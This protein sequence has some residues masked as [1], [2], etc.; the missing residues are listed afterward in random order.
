MLRIQLLGI[1]SVEVDGRAIKRWPRR[2]AIA[3]IQLLALAPGLRCS[4][5]V[6]EERLS[7]EA[8]AAHS[9]RSVSDALYALRQA[10]DAQTEEGASLRYLGADAKNIWLVEGVAVID[11]VDFEMAASELFV[12]THP[13]IERIR[14]TF[15]KYDG[16]LL[17][18]HS[19]I[20]SELLMPVRIEL[21]QKFLHVARAL[22]DHQIHKRDTAGAIAT[23][24]RIVRYAPTDEDAHRR[25]IELFTSLGQ[26]HEAEQQ[27]SLCRSLL[28]RELG[29][30]PMDV[31]INSIRAARAK[32]KEQV[33]EAPVEGFAPRYQPPKPLVK[34]IGREHTVADIVSMLY[35]DDAPRLL[36]LCGIGG[37]GKTQLALEIAHFVYQGKKN[38]AV[39][40]DLTRIADASAVPR[41]IAMALGLKRTEKC[42]WQVCLQQHLQPLDLLLVLDNFEHVHRAAP[43]LAELIEQSPK[44]TVLC[45]S[46]LALL[47]RGEQVVDIEPLSTHRA[48]IHAEC[49]VGSSRS[50]AASLFLR[51]ARIRGENVADRTAEL[52]AIE[53]ICWRLDGLPLAL[54]LAAARS[55]LVGIQALRDEIAMRHVVLVNPMQDA[56]RRHKSMSELLESICA[57]LDENCK[58]GLSFAS[59][60]ESSF[61]LGL[62]VDGQL[63]DATESERILSRLLEIRVLSVD[64]AFQGASEMQYTR[65]FRLL[66]TV[67]TYA[68]HSSG[69]DEA[70]QLIVTNAF[71]DVWRRF[72][73]HVAESRFTSQELNAHDEFEREFENVVGAIRVAGRVCI[74][75]AREIVTAV[76]QPTVRRGHIFDLIAWIEEERLL[77][78]SVCQR[79]DEVDLMS[80][81]CE[82]YRGAAN[83]PQAQRCGEISTRDIAKAGGSAVAAHLAFAS[84]LGIQGQLDNAETHAETALAAALDSGDERGQIDAHTLLSTINNREGDFVRAHSQALAARSLCK[85]R[86][87]ELPRA[88]VANLALSMRFRGDIEAAAALFAS[89]AIQCHNQREIR[90]EAFMTLDQAECETLALQLECA[91]DSIERTRSL[92][93]THRITIL[94]CI[95]HQQA[96]ALHVLRGEADEA[97]AALEQSLKA[98]P[99]C[100]Q[101]LDQ[102]DIT[103]LWLAHARRLKGQIPEAIDAAIQLTSTKTKVRMFIAPFVVETVACI[104][105]AIDK[106]QALTLLDGA[107]A[108]RAAAGFV[109]TPAETRLLESVGITD[110]VTSAAKPRPQDH[111]DYSRL[112]ESLIKQCHHALSAHQSLCERATDARFD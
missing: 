49:A 13:P 72:A 23:L 104:L 39:F 90:A 32:R 64:H 35:A 106:A 96:G 58:M 87:A 101:F 81:A 51:A 75:R 65:R 1:F 76:W 94:E 57:V 2:T 86:G 74:D 78:E 18:T 52:S 31:T 110:V 42:S 29:V 103:L 21:E 105:Y 100:S 28:A 40:V 109:S 22:V 12:E 16:P 89:S 14:S 85:T 34:L 80:A 41:A 17:D 50:A 3:L 88:L 71:V 102:A 99:P 20:T 73:K 93:T 24:H 84:A 67:R 83:F 26:Y 68:R 38:G 9:A 6:L 66:E 25:L 95:L 44:V 77:V 98:M 48:L 70:Q 60:F 4:R 111:P 5:S 47:V 69:L 43:L 19:E 107:S 55:C 62:F 79:A 54:E 10:I 27:L 59:Q 37:I 56:S 33:S 108:A 8:L 112:V 61:T 15:V 11:S 91:R 45:T 30:R 46:R 82:A 53:E 63:F 7:P 97:C 36:T 92:I